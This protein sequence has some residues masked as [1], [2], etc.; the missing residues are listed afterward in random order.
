MSQEC[1]QISQTFH[2]FGVALDPRKI[3]SLLLVRGWA[4]NWAQ[5]LNAIG[6][7]E[8]VSDSAHWMER[9]FFPGEAN[10]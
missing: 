2:S 10:H 9:D 7:A 6:F 3:G 8:G 4:Q 5:P 1:A